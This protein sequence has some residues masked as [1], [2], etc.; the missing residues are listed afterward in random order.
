MMP[1]NSSSFAAYQCLSLHPLSLFKWGGQQMQGG[2]KSELTLNRDII[3][4]LNAIWSCVKP[5]QII[6]VCSEVRILDFE[7]E[8]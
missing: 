6:W 5:H 2:K 8:C 7:K 3:L 1:S 4:H